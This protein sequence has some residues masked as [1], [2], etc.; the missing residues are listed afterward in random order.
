MLLLALQLICVR[1]DEVGHEPLHS[2]HVAR[3]LLIFPQGKPHV[4]TFNWR[5]S[6][7]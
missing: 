7:I 5:T 2:Q 1:T 3:V 6:F 4:E